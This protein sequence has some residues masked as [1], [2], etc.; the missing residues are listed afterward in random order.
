[1]RTR[2]DAVATAGCKATVS[3]LIPE[4]KRLRPPLAKFTEDSIRRKGLPRDVF[5]LLHD[6]CY[7]HEGRDRRSYMLRAQAILSSEVQP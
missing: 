4:R 2:T 6:L 1:M 3:T 5:L 7:D